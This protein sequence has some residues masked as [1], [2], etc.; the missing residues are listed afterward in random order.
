MLRPARSS[1]DESRA[2]LPSMSSRFQPSGEAP[3]TTIALMPSRA[4]RCPICPPT[5][6][7]FVPP[8]S[9]LLK[10]KLVR[11]LVVTAVPASR[12]GAMNSFAASL[13]GWMRA[14]VSSSSIREVRARPPRSA[15]AFGACSSVTSPV[16]MSTRMMRS[17]A[18]PG[19]APSQPLR[20]AESLSYSSPATGLLRARASA[21]P[22]SLCYRNRN[23]RASAAPCVTEVAF[24]EHIER[25]A[26]QERPL[27][28]H[29]PSPQ[30]CSLS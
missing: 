3:E 10:P 11:P 23:S 13:R 5:F 28:E 2:P 1:A 21:G 19:P 18:M 8:V 15:Y 20:S 26:L 4:S 30:A 22:P 7:S 29:F 25:H 6:A 12:P 14:S 27:R 16:V 24:R 17:M 9:G